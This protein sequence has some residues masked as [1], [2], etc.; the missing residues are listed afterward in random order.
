MNTLSKRLRPNV[1]EH[2]F[3]L[4]RSL[5]GQ[6]IRHM[7]LSRRLSVGDMDTMF[8]LSVLIIRMGGEPLQSK[9]RSAGSPA[10]EIGP[11]PMLP[12]S[13]Q[14]I[15][16]ATG[17]PRETVRRKVNQLVQIG[18]VERID[19]GTKLGLTPL[20]YRDSLPIRDSWIDL[21]VDNYLAVD[22]LLT[23]KRQSDSSTY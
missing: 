19:G 13:I 12:V 22:R 7:A 2:S 15:A 6:L 5:G 11:I 17:I 3:E 20:G 18:W 21:V 14:F 1:E 10:D 4:K 16:R 8:V 9:G 23:R